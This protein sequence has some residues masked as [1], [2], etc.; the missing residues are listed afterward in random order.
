MRSCPVRSPGEVRVFELDRSGCVITTTS[1]A[2]VGSPRNTREG[3]KHRLV[4]VI[5]RW[6]FKS[7]V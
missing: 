4:L 7:W 6:A 5:H 1:L 2:Y 3:E